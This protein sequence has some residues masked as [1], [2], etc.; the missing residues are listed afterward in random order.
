MG[1]MGSAVGRRPRRKIRLGVLVLLTTLA[2]SLASFSLVVAALSWVECRNLSRALQVWESNLQQGDTSTLI[3]NLG[4][5]P[6]G[7]ADSA[8][9]TWS[10]LQGLLGSKG[11]RR[12]RREKRKAA[13]T[14]SRSPS[15]AH[16]KGG[17]IRHWSD[18]LSGK[19][20]LLYNNR[21]GEFTV[22]KD[23]IYYIYSQVHC[24]DNTTAYLKLDVKVDNVVTFKCLQGLPPT[25]LY[26]Q[27][28]TVHSCQASGLVRLFKDSRITIHSIAGVRLKADTFTYF[29]LFKL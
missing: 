13:G 1:G 14:K 4:P 24:D 17:V 20:P 27:Q 29:G 9:G 5:D 2:I 19:S 15:A 18:H 22:R 12:K 25:P 8:G 3:Q 7:E 21:T 23:G 16:F 26:S 11:Q 6:L 28:L 10:F